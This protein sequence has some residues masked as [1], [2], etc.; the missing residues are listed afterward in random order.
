MIAFFSVFVF[1]AS[2]LFHL[3]MTSDGIIG[4]IFTSRSRL[5]EPVFFLFTFPGVTVEWAS[6][7]FY[8]LAES[9]FALPTT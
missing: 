6:F 5:G 1:L 3:P 7:S 8:V 4:G 9:P 2:L